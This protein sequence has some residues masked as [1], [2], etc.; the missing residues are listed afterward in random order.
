MTGALS[1]SLAAQRDFVANASHQLRTP[2]T[3][4]GCGWKRFAAKAEPPQ[5]R[6][7]RPSWNCT[8]LVSWWM[9]CSRSSAPP[10]ATAAGQ[11][12]TSRQSRAPPA[13]AGAPRP[14]SGTRLRVE[15]NGDV[16]AFADPTDLA[17]VV[18]NL[19]E[20]ALRYCPPG[21]EVSLTTGLAGGQSVLTVSDTGP[22][23]PAQTASASSSA[24]TAARAG[25]SFTRNGTR[26]RDRGRDRHA[27][28]RERAVAGRA[29]H[30]RRGDVAHSAYRFLTRALTRPCRAVGTVEW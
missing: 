13:S 22:G 11:R 4:F 27:L 2:L 14:K 15:M 3:G 28:G 29:W 24:S 10:R 12:S 5:S 18:D 23:I 6:R 1:A 21:T 19:V 9:T 25:G 26:T 7:Q 20:N 17:N 30:S 8:A 16:F